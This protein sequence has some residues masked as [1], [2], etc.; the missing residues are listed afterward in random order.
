MTT[1]NQNCTLH[2]Q[3]LKGKLLKHKINENDP[4]KERKEEKRN[5]ENWKT[6]L[7]ISM[8]TYL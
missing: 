7:K 5:I 2:S 4:T 3:K 8:N 1:T 6:G